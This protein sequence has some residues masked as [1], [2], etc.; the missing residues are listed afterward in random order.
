MRRVFNLWL[1][2]STRVQQYCIYRSSEQNRVNGNPIV[3]GVYVWRPEMGD[4]PPRNLKLTLE[5]GD[6]EDE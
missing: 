1:D 3:D 5:W 6:T 4:T 2:T